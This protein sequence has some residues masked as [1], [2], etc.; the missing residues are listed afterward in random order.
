MSRLEATVRDLARRLSSASGASWAFRAALVG[1]FVVY[2]AVGRN[3]WFTRDDWAAVIT[4]ERVLDTQGWQNWLFDPQDGHWLTVPFLIFAA[5]RRVFGLDS[6]WPFLIPA[7]AAHVGSVCLVRIICLRNHVSPWTTTMVCTLLLVFGAGWENL[8]FAIQICYNLSLFVFLAQIV[9]VSHDGPADRRDFLGAGLAVI[10][11]MS[12]GFGPI[13]MVGVAILLALRQRWKPLLIAVVPQGLAYLW[14]L[15]TWS[16]DPAA[17]ARPGNQSQ[18]PAFVAGGVSETFAAMTSLPGLAGIA[19]IATLAVA[20]RAGH[21]RPV[22]TTMLALCATVAVMYSA[23][24]VQ[25]VGFGLE[26]AESSRYT[27]MAAMIVAPAFALMIDHLH[28]IGREARVAGLV[29]VA[30]SAGVNVSTFAQQ[31]RAWSI[32]TRDEEYSLEL[33]AGSGLTAGVDPKRVLLP[34]SPDVQVE[35]LEWLVEEG[36]ITPRVPVDAAEIARV[37]SVLGLPP[38]P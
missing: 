37:R 16:S 18:L 30:V 3:Q 4:R 10:G 19:I 35:W 21:G 9:L 28:R 12:S 15:V 38:A 36:A 29:V 22:Q 1:A 26:F 2:V 34:R 14:W 25:R 20:M 27:H 7:L 13:F 17:D 31:A 11:M 5:V 6:Y 23:I 32:M 33:I 24:G 8:V